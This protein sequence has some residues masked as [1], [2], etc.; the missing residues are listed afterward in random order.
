MQSESVLVGRLEHL[1][2]VMVTK[3][4]VVWLPTLNP[5]VLLETHRLN[6]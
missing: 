2:H 4:Y 1:E 3:G 6:D 5:L